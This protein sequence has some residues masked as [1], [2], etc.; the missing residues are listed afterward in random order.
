MSKIVVCSDLHVDAHTLGIERADDVIERL[1]DVAEAAEDADLFIFLGDLLEGHRPDERIWTLVSRVGN[2]L[3]SIECPKLL[4]A[5]NHD[6]VDRRGHRS[7]LAVF[8]MLDDTDVSEFPAMFNWPDVDVDVVTLPHVS[9]AH[10]PKEFETT[11]QWIDAECRWFLENLN[12]PFIVA[13]HLELEE[14]IEFPG[15]ERDMPSGQRAPILPRFFLDD[16]RVLIVV[17]GHYHSPQ[18]IGK[19]RIVGSAERL[20]ANEAE[21]DRKGYIVLETS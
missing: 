4:V 18:D 13:S 3:R 21:D 5:G 8:E 9:S 11:Q 1:E 6:V 10:M 16:D 7:A 12:D 20:T 17:Q 19:I 2:L 14:Q 15:S